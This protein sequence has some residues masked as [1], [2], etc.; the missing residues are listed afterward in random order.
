ME[1]FVRIAC[2][3]FDKLGLTLMAALVIALV[4]GLLMAV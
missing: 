1:L 3:P 2:K 4:S